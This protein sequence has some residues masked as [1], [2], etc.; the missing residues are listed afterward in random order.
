MKSMR[1]SEK[2]VKFISSS[3]KSKDVNAIVE[4]L[5]PLRVYDNRQEKISSLVLS[6][7]SEKSCE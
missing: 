1:P 5:Y 3:V 2:V 7:K 6:I 4:Y